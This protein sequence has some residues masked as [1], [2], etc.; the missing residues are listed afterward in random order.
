MET[1][2]EMSTVPYPDRCDG[3]D[4]P[5]VRDNAIEPGVSER[6]RESGSEPGHGHHVANRARA[7][8]DF[9]NQHGEYDRRLRPVAAAWTEIFH[10]PITI[11]EV[12]EALAA[13]EILR[14][15]H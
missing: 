2:S 12:S 6:W 8:A 14:A 9:T 7:L 10:R 4:M 15:D 1:M 11:R 5:H 13:L 3:S